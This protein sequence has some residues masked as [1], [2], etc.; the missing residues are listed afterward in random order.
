MSRLGSVMT[1]AVRHLS[2]HCSKLVRESGFPANRVCNFR[3]LIVAY[4]R[5][6][7]NYLGFVQLA[8]IVILLRQ[9]CMR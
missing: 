4:E 5:H 3:R 7:L 1:V 6:A 8:C 2:P 9:G